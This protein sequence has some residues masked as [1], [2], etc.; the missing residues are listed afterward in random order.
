MSSYHDTVIVGGGLV[1]GL[2]ALL[3]A[4]SGIEAMVL[5]AARALDEESITA[6]M[7]SRV[8]A[9]NPATIHLLKL[10]QVWP[11]IQRYAPYTGMHVW[12]KNGAGDIE[13]GHT[14]Q[15]R[16]PESEWLGAMVEPS[17][18]NL[19]IQQRM[20]AVLA[21]Y[22]TDVSIVDIQQVQNQWQI[23]LK[24]GESIQTRL[25]IGADGAKSFVRQQANIDLKV[26]DYQQS[27]I[28][29]AIHTELP[30]Q[31]V[32]RQI[33]LPTG[34]LAYLPIASETDGFWQSIVWTLPTSLCEQY[35]QYSDDEFAQQ[36]TQSSLYMLGQVKAIRRRASFPLKACTAE[37]YVLPGLA[38]VGDAAHVIHPLAGQGV[39]IGC[40][41]AAVLCDTLVKS[42]SKTT[43]WGGID[44]LKH[45]AQRRKTHNELMMHGMTAMEW[46]QSSSVSSVIWARSFGL[47]QVNQSNY[48]KKFFMKQASGLS[49]L[50]QTI[51]NY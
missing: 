51:Y 16:P 1:G 39:N 32:A 9:L 29:C 27:A 43:E 26:L 25:L 31:Y 14:S 23:N 5:D 36:L 12:N 15:D 49:I 30:N 46:L 48:L 8:L 33:F 7:D 37:H 13:F 42:L 22:H 11:L 35:M 4:R 38:L 44:V 47:K 24:N 40:L 34:P 18:L 6:N 20:K 45:Y 2:T 17:I 50:K 19:A 3:L 28:G 10:V 21:F 41:D